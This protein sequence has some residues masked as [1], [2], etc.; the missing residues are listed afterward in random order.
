MNANTEAKKTS[1]HQGSKAPRETARTWVQ[2]RQQ[3]EELG[4]ADLSIPIYRDEGG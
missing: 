3:E 4:T 2:Q 1:H